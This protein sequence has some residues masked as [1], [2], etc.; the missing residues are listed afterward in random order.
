MGK[1][2]H[3]SC[4][5]LQLKWTKTIQNSSILHTSISI[6]YVALL[7]NPSHLLYS[8]RSTSQNTS[9]VSSLES[10]RWCI[11]CKW[12]TF[13]V[14]QVFNLIFKAQVQLPEAINQ[15]LILHL[16]KYF[17]KCHIHFQCWSLLLLA[18]ILLCVIAS[19]NPILPIIT[20]QCFLLPI[21]SI[22]H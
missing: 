18:I 15:A 4:N 6:T 22:V 16:L 20:F 9:A 3:I 2:C 8:D 11:S 21:T 1:I 5:F 7:V 19:L 14:I 13:S 12:C 10:P 17:E